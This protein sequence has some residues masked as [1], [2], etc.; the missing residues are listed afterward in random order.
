MHTPSASNANLQ[1]FQYSCARKSLQEAASNGGS[2]VYGCMTQQEEANWNFPGADFEA[3][4]SS[5]LS[6]DKSNTAQP[7]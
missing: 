3:G 6:I 5:F 1:K 4:F 2:S 7:Q